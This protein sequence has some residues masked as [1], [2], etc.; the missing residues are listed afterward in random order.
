MSIKRPVLALVVGAIVTFALVV[1]GPAPVLHGPIVIDTGQRAVPPPEPVPVQG[2]LPPQRIEVPRSVEKPA[3]PAESPAP[4]AEP[5]GM[6]LSSLTSNDGQP[7]AGRIVQ[8]V[9]VAEGGRP[10]LSRKTIT[11]NF[12]Q[13]LVDNIPIGRW[14]ARYLGPARESTLI[15]S[16]TVLGEFEVAAGRTTHFSGVVLGDRTLEGVVSLA[17]YGD[18]AIRVQLFALWDL[19]S[20]AAEGWSYAVSDVDRA[21]IV[22]LEPERR[23]HYPA[24]GAFRFAGLIPGLYRL[25]FIASETTDGRPLFIER[26]VDLLEGSIQLPPVELTLEQ[27]L[28][29]LTR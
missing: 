20:P 2:E 26:E 22:K 3:V 11:D 10:E 15:S 23:K 18:A 9:R 5:A 17:G 6:L 4:Q 7:L 16:G 27:L 25:R 24:F 13:S 14:V 19:T 21:R 12:G 29:A 1:P 28:A 8:F